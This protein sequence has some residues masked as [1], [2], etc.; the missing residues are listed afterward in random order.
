MLHPH[1]P[2]TSAPPLAPVVEDGQQ[3]STSGQY[4]QVKTM[5]KNI[6]KTTPKNAD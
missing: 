1:P 4:K 3:V 2:Q 5:A 6:E